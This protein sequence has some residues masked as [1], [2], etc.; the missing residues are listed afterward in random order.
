MRTSQVD[1]MQIKL[2]TNWRGGCR[3]V[4]YCYLD[5]NLTKTQLWGD[6]VFDAVVGSPR[7][8]NYARFCL[9][10][11]VPGVQWYNLSMRTLR[12]PSSPPPLPLKVSAHV[13][14]N[15]RISGVHQRDFEMENQRIPQAMLKQSCQSFGPGEQR[16]VR[17]RTNVHQ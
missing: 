12:F 2:P 4:R 15:G 11:Q 6:S 9:F 8:Q 13:M 3:Q 17:A 14:W 16:V 10:P 1:E 7:Q 5:W